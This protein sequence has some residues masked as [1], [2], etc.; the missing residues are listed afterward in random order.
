MVIP[1]VA[2]YSYK[3]LFQLVGVTKVVNLLDPMVILEEMIFLILSV[4]FLYVSI[5]NHL[6][7]T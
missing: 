2:S 5:I 4:I 7:V 3:D 6:F 1:M